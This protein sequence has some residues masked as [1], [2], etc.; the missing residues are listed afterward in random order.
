MSRIFFLI[1][2]KL[3]SENNNSVHDFLA[4]TGDAEHQ[5]RANSF[6][7]AGGE[8]LWIEIEI[9]FANFVQLAL[10]FQREA[11]RR[12]NISVS[13]ANITVNEA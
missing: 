1:K 5:F 11:V 8:G 4:S 10:K 12:K 9:P 3:R 13:L 7:P 2:S 6:D